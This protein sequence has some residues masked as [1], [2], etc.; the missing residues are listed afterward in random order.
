MARYD[1]SRWEAMTMSVRGVWS[2]CRKR[3]RRTGTPYIRA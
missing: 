1:A 2:F 3:I